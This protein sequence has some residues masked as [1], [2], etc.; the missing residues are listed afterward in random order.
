MKESPLTSKCIQNQTSRTLSTMS[1]KRGELPLLFAMET[2]LVIS[3]Q[4]SEKKPN[5]T[6]LRF[7]LS[8]GYFESNFAPK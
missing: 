7:V 3:L 8:L 6:L 1:A 5:S 4:I 2:R